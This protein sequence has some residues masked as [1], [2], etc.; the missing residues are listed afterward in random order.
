MS[1]LRLRAWRVA[2][3]V[4]AASVLVLLIGA[5]T[6]LA[7][8]D[9]FGNVAPE[10]Q[11]PEGGLAE[12][13]PLSH[14]ALD[15]HFDGVKASLTGGVDVSGVPP[16]IAY[17]LANALWQLTAFIA[18]AVIT[19]FTFAFSLDLVSG[20][21]ATGGAGALAP[22]ADAV[23]AIYSD[24]FGAPWLAVAIVLTGMWAMWRALIQ[25]RY[26]ETA[27]ALGL[28]VVFVVIALAFVTQPE[29]TIGS[30][31][32]WSNDMSAA[33][34][35]LSQQG[36]VGS[37]QEAKRAAS[38][39]LFQLLVYEPWVVL[40]FGGVEHCVVPDT[41]SDDENPDSVAVRPLASDSGRDAELRRELRGGI[42]VDAEGK[43]CINNRNKYA[44][45]FLR[46]APGSEDR[47][48]E[49]E[50]INEADTGKL[51][52][53]ARSDGYRLTAADKPAVDAMEKGGQYQRLLMALVIFVAQLGVWLLLGSLSVAVILAQ[54]LVLLLLAFA[55]VALVVGVF[56]GRGHD[57]FRGWL[58][59]LVAF[60]LR[61]AIYSLIL[62]VLLAVAAALQA[63]S[64]N[65]GWLLSFGLQALFFWSVFIYR[66]ELAGQLTAATAGP[67][68]D[69]EA[70][71]SRLA[72]MYYA[73]QLARSL[74]GGVGK[75][76]GKPPK[77]PRDPRATSAA[78]PPA[79]AATPAPDIEGRIAPSGGES[80]DDAARDG[81]S[82]HPDTHSAAAGRHTSTP[83]PQ[84]PAPA[85]DTGDDE[86]RRGAGAP[87]PPVPQDRSKVERRRQARP[88]ESGER[89]SSA[90]RSDP[91]PTAS[92]R[93]RPDRPADPARDSGAG[94]GEP[95][96]SPVLAEL[97]GDEQRLDRERSARGESDRARSGPIEGR[98]QPAG[99]HRAASK[100]DVTQPPPRG[101]AQ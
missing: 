11:V 70:A 23:R 30:V 8:S 19:L 58:M 99:K 10:S 3:M 27:G 64:A 43:T 93:S 31:S 100:P 16:L 88:D 41:G 94:A 24:V 7:A 15:Q 92:E 4:G 57:F 36:D 97:R 35:S 80:G 52:E 14:Y 34:L 84:P 98:D 2:P 42:Q 26:A 56:P 90:E 18:S 95:T 77:P 28:S 50:A 39:Q 101:R 9:L 5:Q 79:H 89:K 33:F 59:R 47:T 63:A 96:R 86:G 65:L 87:A 68:A 75:P 1:R 45:R 38:D 13:H 22:V 82:D 69:R 54:V 25:R 83:E 60:L 37:E 61:K 21:E 76:K 46:H 55:P 67:G 62:A 78:P 91:A 73:R 81:R 72:A 66:K 71:G 44:N 74:R 53:D 29:R 51:P 6:A 40:N 48:K 32:K 12:R 20:S 85:E 17:F 49:Y